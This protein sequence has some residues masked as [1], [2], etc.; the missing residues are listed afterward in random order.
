MAVPIAWNFTTCFRFPRTGTRHF[1]CWCRSQRTLP[2]KNASR[3]LVTATSS[4]RRNFIVKN[5]SILKQNVAN[6]Y[7]KSKPKDPNAMSWKAV[8]ALCSGISCGIGF[9]I[10]YLG[11]FVIQWFQ[12]WHVPNFNFRD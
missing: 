9:S 7:V 10:S 4:L 3:S 1:A 11:E 8:F 2:T 12:Q 5:T 6:Y